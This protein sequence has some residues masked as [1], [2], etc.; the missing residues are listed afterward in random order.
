MGPLKRMG[1][2]LG[3]LKPKGHVMGPPEAHGPPEGPRG[4]CP[5]C[6]PL[7]GPEFLIVI[8]DSLFIFA[9]RYSLFVIRY[10]L[11]AIRYS[12]FVIRYSLFAIRYSLF[13][14]R[15]SLFIFVIHLR[16]SK[17]FFLLTHFCAVTN[18]ELNAI[19]RSVRNKKFIQKIR[20][21]T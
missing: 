7:G 19:K 3:P 16:Y 6:P 5:P 4:H 12:L 21:I 1:P 13:V 10:S 18:N 2:L 11:F 14:I 20:K 9:I 8:C 15:Y 17:F